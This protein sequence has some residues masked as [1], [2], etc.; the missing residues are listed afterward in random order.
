M[1]RRETIEMLAHIPSSNSNYEN[2]PTS[3]IHT[4]V[5]VCVCMLLTLYV[6][7]YMT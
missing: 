7:V 1:M 3:H 2:G 5:C 6:R 4:Y